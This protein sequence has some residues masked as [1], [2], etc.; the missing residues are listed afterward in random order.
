MHKNWYGAPAQKPDVRF[1]LLRDGVPYAGPI[2]FEN[3]RVLPPTGDSQYRTVLTL[4]LGA[5]LLLMAAWALRRR[6]IAS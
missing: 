2:A 4:A 1:Q 3:Q 5:G 6:N